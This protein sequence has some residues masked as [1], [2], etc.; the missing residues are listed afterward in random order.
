MS[1]NVAINK[2]RRSTIMRS[3]DERGSN[4]F[5]VDKDELFDIASK[6]DKTLTR[7]EYDKLH[8]A[9]AEQANVEMEEKFKAKRAA[10]GKRSKLLAIVTAV[11][12]LFLGLSLAGNLRSKGRTP[13]MSLPRSMPLLRIHYLPHLCFLL[14]H[15]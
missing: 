13:G 14:M 6:D 12:V 15:S 2:Q 5:E 8:N 7:A 9:I 3:L 1:N 11:L 10:S 4:V